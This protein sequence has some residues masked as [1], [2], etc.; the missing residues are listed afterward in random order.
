MPSDGFSHAYHATL[1]FIIWLTLRYP[2]VWPT[3]LTRNF[4]YS[5][6]FFKKQLCTSSLKSPQTPYCI[7]LSAL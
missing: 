7:L 4:W 2:L 3:P 6:G 5:M 1:D